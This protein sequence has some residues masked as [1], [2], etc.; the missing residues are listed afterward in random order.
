MFLYCLIF[1]GTFI[2]L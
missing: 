1:T 2:Y